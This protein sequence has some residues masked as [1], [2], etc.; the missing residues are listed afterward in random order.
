MKE[1]KLKEIKNGRL[2]R[3]LPR[4]MQQAALC[5]D[6]TY[7]DAFFVVW[8]IWVRKLAALH[9]PATA[10]A[11]EPLARRRLMPSSAALSSRCRCP[12]AVLTM[13]PCAAPRTAPQAMLAMLG[14]GA[15][16]TITREGPFQNL[17]D[18]LADPVN[19]NI[20]TNFGACGCEG[21]AQWGQGRAGR[22]PGAST[23]ACGRGADVS[24]FCLVARR[25]GLRL[26]VKSPWRVRSAARLPPAH[27]PLRDER[28]RA[29]ARPRRPAFYVQLAAVGWQAAAPLEKKTHLVE[30]LGELRGA[31][32]S[33]RA[34]RLQTSGFAAA[35]CLVQAAPSAALRGVSR[36]P[37]SGAERPDVAPAS[38]RSSRERPVLRVPRDSEAPPGVGGGCRNRCSRSG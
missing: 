31:E 18:H 38:L 27:V 17:L 12:G 23:W 26:C 21:A 5:R 10:R 14:Y 7:A 20:L 4:A 24:R 16:A 9:L 34:G 25:Q 37:G 8:S 13:P 29:K 3:P 1:L 32:R 19:N 11:L 33:V 28:P 30:M 2:V 22:W 6:V 15:Q 36:P 35:G